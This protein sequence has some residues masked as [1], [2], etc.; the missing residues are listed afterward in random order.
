[1][2]ASI[3]QAVWW[4]TKRGSS[5]LVMWGFFDESGKLADTDFICLCGYLSNERWDKFSSDWEVLLKQ[6]SL[7]SIHMNPLIGRVT[8]YQDI[9]WTQDQENTI[10]R[11]FAKAIR[12]NTLAYFGISLDAEHYR[13]MSREAREVLGQ[14]E[15]M[16]FAFQRLLKLVLL[17]LVQWKFNYSVSIA[18][19]YTEDFSRICLRTLGKLRAR[20]V[21]IKKLVG[22]ITFADSDIFYPLQAADMLAYGTHRNLR[23]V[24]PDYYSYLIASTETDP[25]PHPNS[26]RYGPAE[27]D[28]LY[29]KLKTGEIETF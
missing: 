25:G 28:E 1:M 14:K 6:H 2:P 10:L 27:L 11:Q 4:G 12:E 20:S 18:F 15:A 19:D 13:G 7:P 9:K 24:P 23:D 8:P 16:D 5:T 22:A 17:Q 3:C 26:E 29:R 21:E